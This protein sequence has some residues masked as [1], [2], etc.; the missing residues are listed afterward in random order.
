MPLHLRD[1]V[2]STSGAGPSLLWTLVYPAHS[3]W[4]PQLVE[5]SVTTHGILVFT[6]ARL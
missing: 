5:F 3:I 2:A 4:A 6:G 1:V